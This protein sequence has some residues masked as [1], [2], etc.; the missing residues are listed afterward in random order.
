MRGCF[1][2]ERLVTGIVRAIVGQSFDPT[3]PLMEAGLDSL[4]AVE[5]RST[6]SAAFSVP[7]PATA[8]FDY[9]TVAALAAFIASQTPQTARVHL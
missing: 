9:P 4:G 1:K 5:L 7:L 8:A 2:G 3:V 6:V